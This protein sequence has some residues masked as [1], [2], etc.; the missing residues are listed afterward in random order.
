MKT[1]KT[2]LNKGYIF[3]GIAFLIPAI[4]M[5]GICIFMGITPFGKESFLIADMQKQYV[6]FLSYYKTIFQGENNI[7]YTFGKCLGG[8]MIG[9]FTYYL[10]SPFNLL[11]L[12]LKDSLI[13]AGITILVIARTGLCGTTMAY[14]L[15][16]R[17][18]TENR[19]EIFIFSTSYAMMG[20]LCVNSFNIM[21]QDALILLPCVL[22]GIDKILLG[23]KPYT[24]MAALFGVLFTNYYIGYMICIASVL[25]F[26][27]RLLVCGKGEELLKKLWRFV[28]ASLLAGGLCAFSLLPTFMTL[29]GSL[30]DGKD[31]GVGITLPNL[32]PVRVLSKI[33]TMAYSESELMNGMPVIF[34]GILMVV[35]VILFFFNAKIP[36][37]ERIV[38]G[39][40][41]GVLM[42]SFCLAKVDYVWHAF[43]EPSGY[44]YRY[45]FLFSF[46]M[47]VFSWQGFLHLK[48]GLDTKR[49]LF[50]GGTF[51][52]LLFFIFR[53]P[54]EYISIKKALPD[55]LLFLMMLLVIYLIKRG[56]NYQILLLLLAVLQVGDLSLNSIYTYMK[57]RNTSYCD[58]EEYAEAVEKIGPVVE[59]VKRNDDS[60]YRMENLEKK[61]N[62]DAMHFSYAG[63]THYSSN[64]K[65]FVLSFLE[66]MGL[67]YN[68]LYVE[69]GNGSTQTV[70]SLF[71]VKYLLGSEETINKSY[72]AVQEGEGLSVYQNP[73]ALPIAFLAEEQVRLV[74]MEE[75][76]PFAL[77]N[78]MY[79][80]AAGSEEAILK[81][82][83]I[84][85]I[86]MENSTEEKQG[87]L[88][89]Y[90]RKDEKSPIRVSFEMET[91]KDGRVYAYL[92]AQEHL[93]SAEIYVDG[94][95]LCGYMNRSN[96]KI[97]NLG[98]YRKGEHITFTVQLDGEE[99]W[100]ENAYFVTED[101][102]ALA[103]NYALLMKEQAEVERE[104][105]SH[106]TVTTE[107][108]EKKL[109]V[110]S[111]PYEDDWQIVVDG[112]KSSGEIVYDTFLAIA[113]EP[114]AHSI[115][116]RYIPKGTVAGI[117]VTL[118]CIG[119]LVVMLCMEKRT[120]RGEK[121]EKQRDI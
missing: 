72:Q 21:W 88:T 119:V 82:A 33:F 55:I 26:G 39:C 110:F 45:S 118:G 58:A 32:R 50:A 34:C 18:Q 116:L 89:V 49:L 111:I 27:Y 61:N 68:R 20:Y 97:L 52:A 23:K 15:K 19:A 9:F 71:G 14:Y 109:L 83:V 12:F 100:L 3:Y 28:Y 35:L 25:Y 37:R 24:Y 92:T 96:W 121:Y 6:D 78:A 73:Y 75:E 64:E 95:F 42:G 56:K 29:Q 87:D 115:E 38:S 79:Q 17:F 30:K 66:K 90:R 107:N 74:D 62:N 99:L 13:P 80:M 1:E 112:K 5:L 98:E 59:M 81:D 40:M 85:E 4:C 117:A 105:S 114:G 46:F 44:H 91:V 103:G 31:L 11:F 47:I 51:F 120:K 57:N 102:E 84:K 63:L 60:L 69:Y 16:N 108:A 54:Y 7:F 10:M 93:Q 41:L 48:E 113:L 67:N 101:E 77:Q 94:Q 104:S 86:R 8:D 53:H 65:N 22:Y 70:D 36:R 106:L 2:F 43:M 76:N